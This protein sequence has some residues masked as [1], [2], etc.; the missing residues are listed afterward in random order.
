MKAA[1][2]MLTACAMAAPA[3]AQQQD[4]ESQPVRYLLGASVA[5]HP[6]YD[7]ASARQTRLS[8]L[9][10]L[11]IGRWRFSTASGSALLG[12]GREGAGAGASTQ[13]IDSDKL[14]LGLALRVDGGR[15]SND[16]STTRGLPDVK[17]TLRARLYANYSLAP[18][19]NL[20]A[21]LSR[22]LLGHGGGLNAGVDLGWRFYRSATLEWTGGIGISAADAQNMRSYFGVPESA[23]AAS[24]K[25]AYAPGAGLRDLHVGVGFTRPFARQWF[26]FGSAGASRLLGPAARSPLV[27]KRDGS[28]AAIGLAW[29]N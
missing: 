2:L 22:D 10:A 1:S 24:G 26:V 15:S 11:K 8:A 4:Q 9:W 16:A 6:E 13:L 23:V 18:D 7:G 14:R 21:A 27:E 5:S 12:F 25:P 28:H 17:R 3:Q 29:R 19:L 20:G